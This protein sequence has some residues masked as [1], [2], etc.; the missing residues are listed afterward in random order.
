VT[1]GVNTSIIVILAISFATLIFSGP[2]LPHLPN[3]IGI[4]LVG[5][6]AIAIIVALTSSYQASIASPQSAAAAVSALI[7]TSVAGQLSAPHLREGYVTVMATM[8]VSALL[9]GVVMLALGWFRLGRLIRFIPYPVV[10]GFLA[11]TGWVLLHGS[12]GVMTQ[13]PFATSDL[14]VM[15]KPDVLLAWMPG[16]LFGAVLLLIVRRIKNGL[17]MPATLLV[18]P[19]LFY[20]WLALTGSSVDAAAQQGLIVGGAVEATLWEPL[21]PSELA[22]VDWGLV[23]SHVPAMLTIVIVTVL[24]LLLNATGIELI[25]ERR[26]DL[27][28]ELLACGLGNVATGLLGGVAGFQA[29]TYTT[30][31][32]QLGARGRL[33]GIMTGLGIGLVFLAGSDLVALI[34]RFVLG[35]VLAFL[36]LQLLVTWLVDTRKRISRAEYAVIILIV[37]L[38]AIFGYLLGVAFGVIAA[39]ALFVL[40]YSRVSV[41][42]H[43]LSGRDYQ[44]KVVRSTDARHVLEEHG[45][46]I[47]IFQ[48]Q[49]FIFFGTAN[50]LVDA[51]ET[52]IGD[53]TLPPMRY[54]VLDFRRVNKIDSSAALSFTRLR[55]LLHTAGASLV[56]TSVSSQIE[57]QIDL[58]DR[59]TACSVCVHPELDRGV[60]WAENEIL[61]AYTPQLSQI[62]SDFQGLMKRELG[63][64]SLTPLMGYLERQEVSAGGYVAR[65][66]EAGDEMFFIESG[67]LSVQLEVASQPATR[68]RTATAGAVLGEI[69]AYLGTLR[70][71]SIVA[72]QASVIYRLSSASLTRMR[73][74]DPALA[75]AF[76][77]YMARTLAERLADTTATLQAVLR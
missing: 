44:S 19:V 7:A 31:G 67:L 71:A 51:A 55:Q 45:D 8:G 33:T 32:H 60:E 61:S 38:T 36:G 58:S 18:A 4:V 14:S 64:D 76:N 62:Q 27:N 29:L 69:G 28:R 46:E 37:V 20:L 50:S 24:S 10:G 49:G 34:P 23:L 47:E 1:A 59:M 5:A 77:A 74:E 6:V 66:G 72:E 2:L 12:F 39:I 30:L 22:L 16:L 17:S 41:V 54:L 75:A 48:L 21:Q 52:R 68:V 35:G 42:K 9:V 25:V 63:E 43:R 73:Q 70:T 57:Q 13:L 26:L 53:A 65:Q 3:A 40:D 15:L 56:L 11:G